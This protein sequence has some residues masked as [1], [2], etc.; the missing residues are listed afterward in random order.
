[1]PVDGPWL[2]QITPAPMSAI[3]IIITILAPRRVTSLCERLASAIEL[4]DVASHATPVSRA[5]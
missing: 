4:S 5:L 3:P 1:M 2:A